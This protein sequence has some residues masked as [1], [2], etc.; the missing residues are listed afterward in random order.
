[1]CCSVACAVLYDGQRKLSG[2]TTATLDYVVGQA[3]GAAATMRNFT[4]LLEAAK[5]AGGGVAS[6][7][8]DVARGV[9]DVARRVDAA[10]DATAARAASNSR[11]IRTSLDA[12]YVRVPKSVAA[13]SDSSPR[14]RPAWFLILIGFLLC[15]WLQKEGPDRRRGRDAGPRPRWLR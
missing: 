2:S 8:P 1:V 14:L 10:A 3:D 12:V 13:G 6:L 5:T 9:D 7:P 11:R 15:V 4:A